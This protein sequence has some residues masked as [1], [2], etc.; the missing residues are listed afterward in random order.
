MN[1]EINICLRVLR[2]IRNLALGP[3]WFEPEVAVLFSVAHGAIIDLAGDGADGFDEY[4]EGKIPAR[5]VLTCLSALDEL[6]TRGNGHYLDD[7]VTEIGALAKY[8][9]DMLIELLAQVTTVEEFR[10]ELT[11]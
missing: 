2:T 10:R 1:E 4:R 7:G 9:H 5:H 8:A 6:E 11:R 3:D